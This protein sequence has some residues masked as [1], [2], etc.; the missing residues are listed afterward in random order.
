MARLDV[1]IVQSMLI[2]SVGILF[3]Y[4]LH[5]LGLKQLAGLMRVVIIMAI[6]AV[7]APAVWAFLIS[8]KEGIEAGVEW[9]ELTVDK[10]TFWR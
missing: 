4:L 7:L 1:A 10:I 3:Y 6:I 5:G 2:A 8:V 9:V